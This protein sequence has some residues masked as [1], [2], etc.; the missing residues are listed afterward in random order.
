M[1]E[2]DKIYIDGSLHEIIDNDRPIF[3]WSVLSYGRD[4]F[5]DSYELSIIDK[6]TGI[7]SIEPF[8]TISKKTREQSIEYDGPPFEEGGSYMVMLSV[9]D[10]KGFKSKPF[11]K[12]FI[13]GKINFDSPWIG[14][15]QDKKEAVNEFIY[16]FDAK[17]RVKE[18]TLFVS[19][20]GYHKAFINGEEI[21]GGVL[22]PSGS[23]YNKTCYYEVLK[24][25]PRIIQE[26]NEISILL[27]DGWRRI[28]VLYDENYYASFTGKPM[29]N[30]M[31][32]IS[33]AS[34]ETK[35]VKTNKDWKWKNTPYTSASVFGGAVYDQRFKDEIEKEVEVI[36]DPIGE[37]R[38]DIL[39]PIVEQKTYSP[40]SIVQAKDKSF[41]VDFGQNMA[42]YCYLKLPS[43]LQEGQEVILE[44][45]E[46]LKADG[47]LFREPLRKAEQRDKFI[48]SGNP[49]DSIWF[50]PVFT[51]HGFRYVRVDGLDF[52]RE[53]D[54]YAVSVYNNIDLKSEFRSGN[55]LLNKIHKNSRMT[56]RANIH[57]MMTDC[58][59]RDERM[60]WLNDST[61]RF[62]S[63]PYSFNIARLFTKQTRDIINDQI[64]GTITCTAPFVYGQR[65]ADPVCSSFLIAG[66]KSYYFA[67]NKKILEEAYE[68]YKAWQ[69]YLLSRSDN[70]IV[71]YSYYGDWAGPAYACMDEEFAVS[72][73]TPGILMSTGYSYFNCK[74]LGEIAGILGYEEEKKHYKDL[75]DKIQKA[76]LDNWFDKNKLIVGTGSQA[77]HAFSLWLG[78]IPEEYRQGVCEL[79]RE[80]LV[81][82]DYMFTTGNLCTR[83]MLEVLS[84]YGYVDDVYELMTKDT[85]PSFGYMIQ[86]EATTF[87]ERFELK[88]NPLMN[89]HNHP[90]YG[91]CDYWFYA[92]LLGIKPKASA[93]DEIAI[94]PYFPSKLLSASGQV[95]TI[96]GNIGVRWIRQYGK[97]HLYVS[98]PFGISATIYFD[99]KEEKVGSGS[100]HFEAI[101]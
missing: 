75:E 10:T 46:I 11:S 100:Y 97:V 94:R 38:A 24:V 90:M 99:G 5:Q 29:L 3:S 9:T 18:A 89:S 68:S 39:E 16:K 36:N 47:S 54:I 6:K 69:D 59:Q 80:D 62:D 21:R 26:N 85:Y 53:E 17:E 20:I 57:S 72:R 8:W 13:Q 40:V 51:Y 91:A 50:H 60:A 41:I 77:S 45:A 30:A 2:I 1:I 83:Y 88:E 93:F 44:H 43:N 25:D 58:P 34:G 73:V 63:A 56:E 95:E 81:K 65:P 74:L 87:W 23:N 27:S 70:Y 82:N 52:L 42:G 31:L 15:S 12:S 33:Y 7:L 49:M 64:D 76:F 96:K 19:G 4:L 71:N 98:L 78:I 66:I 101:L 35:W 79:L 37:L 14:A 67:G 86:N 32:K 92:Y 22:A 84:D 28:N 55:P 48:S 61:V